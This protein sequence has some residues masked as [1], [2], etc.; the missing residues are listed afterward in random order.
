[1]N[2]FNIQEVAKLKR[3]AFNLSHERKF[4][5]QMG[6]LYPILCEEVL[7]GDSWKIKSEF[8]CRLSPLATPMMARVDIHTHYFFVPN[9][10]VWEDWE[11]FI[12][13]GEDGDS[14]PTMPYK[15]GNALING[16][17]TLGNYLG[18]QCSQ[19]AGQAITDQYINALPYR[20]YNLIWNEYFRDQNLQDPETI[21]ITSGA[22]NDTQVYFKLRNLHKDYF[23]AALPWTQKGDEVVLPLGSSAPIE[24]NTASS[25][26]Q[27]FRDRTTHDEVF[28]ND[29]S[30]STM[31]YDD[32]SSD[33]LIYFGDNGL[34]FM[35]LDNADL[36]QADLV[37]ATG[38]T[39]NELRTAI[40]VQRWL[41]RNA[42]S[43]SRYSEY[44]LAHFGVKSSDARLQRPEFL[45]GGKSPITISEV[46]QT[47]QTDNTPQG[48][49][50]GHGISVG[51]THEAKKYFEEHGYII[52]LMSIMP[53]VGYTQGTRRHFIKADKFEYY[54]P[55]FAHLGE[56]EVFTDEIY[57]DEAN[58]RDL[59]FGYQ[60]RYT[61]Y[62]T[63]P[64]ST[65]GL[66]L[67]SETA[68]HLDRIFSSTPQL[69][70]SFIAVNGPSSEW[71]RAFADTS[72]TDKY[73][74]QCYHDIK[75]IRPIPVF[76]DPRL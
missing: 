7:P 43:G 16:A 18:I 39:I 19:P 71:N 67:T 14:L 65:H 52:G 11:E 45:G 12:T 47:S 61:E 24:F 50:S 59:V 68:W 49:M 15:N 51:Q 9:R 62:K 38:A 31:Q 26:R 35:E 20:A 55:E 21:D 72:G 46:L 1:M 41:E 69:N 63:I 30:Q 42:R 3:N 22:D 66:F 25:G 60:P 40:H 76:T 73:Y 34:Q 44:L 48:T 4:T 2:Q 54:H 33:N 36:L 53:R 27:R 28:F 5:G 29:L 32:Y 70:N 64:S 13:G 8:L 57:A 37:N 17:S 56:Q 23:T 74:F 75:A 58:E 6:I 10:L